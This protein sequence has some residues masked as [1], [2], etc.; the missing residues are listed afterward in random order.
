[1]GNL[2][3][4]Y[5]S[6]SH[7]PLWILLDKAGIWEANGL[8]VNTSPQ[9]HR[10]KAVDA[11]KSGHVEVIS[12]NHHNL[13]ARRLKGEDFVHLAQVGNIWTETRLVTH[14]ATN[15]VAG[16]KGKRVALGRLSSH[17]GLNVW[18]FLRQEG[19][20]ADRGEVQL[21]EGGSV[22]DRWNGVVTGDFDATFVGAPHYLRAAREGATVVSVRPMPMIRGVTLTT[23]M[24]VMREREP[25][26]RALVRGLV[27]GIHFFL[28]RRNETLSIIREHVASVLGLENEEEVQCIYDEWCGYLERKPYP[29]TEAIENVFALALRRN[30]EVEGLNP[31]SLWD[32]HYLRELDDTGYIDGLYK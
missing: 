3:V 1:M 22:T 24:T 4:I 26:I 12:G 18:L 25:D 7:A 10:E 20:D 32:T 8:H 31:L 14:G 21:V 9:L 23:T 28:T 16:L 17:E 30:P 5:R 11:L 15:G 2:N 19:L 13:F 29:T 27:E 6:N